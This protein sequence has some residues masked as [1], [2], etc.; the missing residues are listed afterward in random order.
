MHELSSKDK[1]LLRLL[2]EGLP[3][4]SRPY[5]KIAEELGTSE[6]EVI[7]RIEQLKRGNIIRRIGGIWDSNRL[8]FISV[9]VALKVKTEFI[10]E[11]AHRINTYTGVTHNYQ[12]DNRFNIWFTLTAEKQDEMDSILAEV[13]NFAGVENLL[14]L[15]AVRQ[16]KVEVKFNWE[17]DNR[18]A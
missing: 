14:K 1:E 17:G 16:F 3:L 9:L 12:R 4:E 7:E 5:Q 6:D 2:Q 10:E 13:R 15:P 18:H 11:V 8:G